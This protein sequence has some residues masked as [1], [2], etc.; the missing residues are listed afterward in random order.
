AEAAD[1]G[2]LAPASPVA[3]NAIVQRRLARTALITNE[4]FRD[5]LAIGTQMRAHVYDLWTPE[6]EPI[7][8]RDL[9]LGVRGRLDAAGEEAEALGADSVRVAAAAL[10][11]RGVEA[12]AV[13]LLFSFIND[14][15]ERRV[16][17][18]LA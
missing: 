14:D 10:P 11:D 15:H 18:I 3:T 4:G 12:V 8:P 13:M 16:G 17:E 9:C 7:A 5:V 1:V 6:P 2:Y